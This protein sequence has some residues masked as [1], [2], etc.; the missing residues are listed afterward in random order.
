VT[1][2][3]SDNRQAQPHVRRRKSASNRRR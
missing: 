2:S 1:N 3:S